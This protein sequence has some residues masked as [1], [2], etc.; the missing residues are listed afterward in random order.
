M[1]LLGLAGVTLPVVAHLLSRR[2]Y[3][4]VSW[5]AMQF[6]DPSRKTRRKMKLE[7]L[8]LL[9]IRI[10]AICLIAIAASRP[11]INSG[12]L[13]GYSSAG[14]RD[15]VLVIDG[16]NSMGRSDGLVSLHQKAIQRAQEFLQTLQPGDTVA[17]I[18]ARDRP[19]RI[20]ESPLQDLSAVSE[21][22][23]GIPPPAG[24]ADLRQA[25]EE[26]VGILGRCSNGSREIVV[27][28]DRQRASWSV[29][30]EAAWNRFDDVL[31]FPSV[32]PSLWVVDLSAGLAPIR[33][34]ISIGR[35]DVSRDLSVPGFPVSLQVPVRNAGEGTTDVPL[36]I[37]LNGQRVANLDATVSV[38]AESETTFSRSIRFSMEGTNLIT[39]KVDLPDD[40]VMADNESHAA[41]RVTTA[42]PVLLVESSS[43]LDRT[44]WNT[45]FAQLALTAPGNKA[46]WIL[47][48]TVRA[49][50]LTPEHL[51]DV[52]AAVLPD[53]VE[54]PE[55]MADALHGF[56]ASGKGV[57]VTL[58]AK[59]S[60][61][62]F[63][64]LYGRVF[65]RLKLKRVRRADPDAVAPTTVAP[66]S[67][68]AAWLN[69]FRE[70]DGA[71]FLTAAFERWWLVEATSGLPEA[72]PEGREPDLPP[73]D[74]QKG[75]ADAAGANADPAGTAPITIAQLTSGD[76]LLL[77]M[78]YGRGS[79]LLMT[80]NIDA[81]WNGLPTRPDY[82]PFLHEALFQMA[83][84]RTRRNV[85]FGE[86]LASIL[87][88]NEDPREGDGFRFSGPFDFSTEAATADSDGEWLVRLPATRLPG[89]YE[90]RAD[91]NMEARPIDS[92]VVNYDHTED[93]P[94]ELI[95]DDHARLIV[96]NRMTFLESMENLRKQMYGEES[97]SELWG[98]LL[99][100]FLGMLMLEV[101]MTRRLVLRGHADTA[102]QNQTSPAAS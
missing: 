60:P 7:E 4:V 12:F 42:I 6:L 85:G 27:L 54:L 23:D 55:G 24:A 89:N 80:S 22:L 61:E 64:E 13:M 86:P 37:L 8:L 53:V 82:V 44:K 43:S 96:H 31:N 94:A 72:A 46:P 73:A 67:L 65:P 1:M 16:S 17:L 92:F 11:W 83:S 18:D 51:R 84:S 63:R 38:P 97:R 57:F 48:K 5:G 79:V 50:D 76:P 26:A 71:S 100:V 19:V 52:A 40:S 59:S 90:L 74:G 62:S 34:N 87:P 3:D 14:S 81:A 93:D 15:V 77:Q 56:V 28:T 21:E 91:Q 101:W 41:V 78:P 33:Q 36:Q 35:L 47:T 88:K 10:T 29:G 95:A 9:L 45:F 70:R 39:V 66:Y 68:E 99:F 30:D 20:I 98:L 69:R 32:R 2:K 25:C 49:R 58:G 75:L 102:R